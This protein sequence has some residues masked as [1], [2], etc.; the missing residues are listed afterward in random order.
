MVVEGRGGE[1]LNAFFLYIFIF[2][3]LLRTLHFSVYFT[4]PTKV[5]VVG[6]TQLRNLPQY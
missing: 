2:Y 1:K 4:N 6:L 5:Y 3:V